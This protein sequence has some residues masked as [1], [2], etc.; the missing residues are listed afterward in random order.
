MTLSQ[1]I[2]ATKVSASPMTSIFVA[3]IDV[4]GKA[5]VIAK[6]IRCLHFIIAKIYN[7]ATPVFHLSWYFE[8]K[9]PVEIKKWCMGIV[10][11]IVINA[12]AS[13][14]SII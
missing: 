3:K 12:G 2:P 10:D 1:R 13:I 14:L 9:V 8:A 11:S 4:I 5:I 7:T 6:G